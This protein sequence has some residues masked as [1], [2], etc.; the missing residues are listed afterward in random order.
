VKPLGEGDKAITASPTLC[1]RT[2]L[3]SM[4]PTMMLPIAKAA[5]LL[6]GDVEREAHAV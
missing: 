6:L 2:L 3:R 5:A 1:M 4:P